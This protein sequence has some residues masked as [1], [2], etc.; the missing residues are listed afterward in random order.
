MSAHCGS[1]QRPSARVA[2]PCGQSGLGALRPVLDL[3]RLDSLLSTFGVPDGNKLC[4]RRTLLLLHDNYYHQLLPSGTRKITELGSSRVQ[5]TNSA[6]ICHHFVAVISMQDSLSLPVHGKRQQQAT[7]QQTNAPRRSPVTRR[8]ER[9]YSLVF[10][11]H[12]ERNCL[13]WWRQNVRP[14]R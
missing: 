4:S 2:G 13:D 9:V 8:Q 3:R 7:E 11:L 14:G 6:S 10:A 12:K 1:W 5:G